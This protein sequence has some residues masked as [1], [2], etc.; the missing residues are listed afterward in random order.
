MA[1]HVEHK[2]ELQ[3]QRYDKHTKPRQ[4]VS[5]EAL[6]VRNF[7]QGDT[8]LAGKIV[9]APDP[10]SYNV[11]LSD[12]RIVRRH[13]DHIRPRSADLPKSSDNALDETIPITVSAQNPPANNNIP[14]IPLRRSTKVSQPPDRL[15]LLHNN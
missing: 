7:A 3:K 11:K 4:F 10:C 6:F 12:D 13:A 15:I 5:D 9:N 2:Q 14:P 8:W 1:S